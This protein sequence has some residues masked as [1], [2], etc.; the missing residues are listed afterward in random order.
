MEEILKQGRFTGNAI[1]R[2]C[3]RGRSE[4]LLV[5]FR[6]RLW[7]NEENKADTLGLLKNYSMSYVCIR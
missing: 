6:N 7:M 5:E 1:Q 2:E 4:H 3:T